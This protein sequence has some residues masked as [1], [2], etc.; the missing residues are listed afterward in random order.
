MQG[1]L[2]TA[3]KAVEAGDDIAIRKLEIQALVESVVSEIGRHMFNVD[4]NA[5]GPAEIILRGQLERAVDA[6]ATAK[7]GGAGTTIGYI[8][9]DMLEKIHKNTPRAA[10]K[11]DS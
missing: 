4:P 5:K 8:A 10:Q 3:L 2:S 11:A 7:L 1:N 9:P 6:Y